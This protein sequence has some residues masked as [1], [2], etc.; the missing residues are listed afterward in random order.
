MFLLEELNETKEENY[1]HEQGEAEELW[2]SVTLTCSREII[3]HDHG[4]LEEGLYLYAVRV[5]PMGRCSIIS[6][7]IASRD[8]RPPTLKGKK[9]K[10][11]R[12]NASLANT[13]TS[14]ALIYSGVEG[15][16]VCSTSYGCEQIR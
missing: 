12:N 5:R 3:F 9:G 2:F 10:F 4:V 14:Y 11:F 16:Y 13:A 15:Y 7:H 8:F 6:R 1:I